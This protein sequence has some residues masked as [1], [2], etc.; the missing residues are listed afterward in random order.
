MFKHMA[1]NIPGGNFLDKSFT[2]WIHQEGIWWM[3]IFRVGTF[4]EG[5]PGIFQIY[6]VKS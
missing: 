2:G 6:L 1:G 5:F 3:G 4:R